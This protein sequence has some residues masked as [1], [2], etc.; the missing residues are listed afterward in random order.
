MSLSKWPPMTKHI[1]ANNHPQ[2]MPPVGP[3]LFLPALQNLSGLYRIILDI[4]GLEVNW[5]QT[6]STRSAKLADD[7]QKSSVS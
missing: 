5:G 4:Q 3:W 2:T 1:L 6:Y 7:K